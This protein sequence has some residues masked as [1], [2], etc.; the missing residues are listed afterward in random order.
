MEHLEVEW[1]SKKPSFTQQAPKQLFMTP[2]KNSP[3]PGENDGTRQ[4]AILRNLAFSMSEGAR[5]LD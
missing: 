5:G 3:W 2:Q 1:C 4:S